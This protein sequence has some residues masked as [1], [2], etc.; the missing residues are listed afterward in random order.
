MA[1]ENNEDDSWLYGSSNEN[2]DNQDEQQQS[3]NDEN[4]ITNEESDQKDAE[5]SGNDKYDPDDQQVSRNE[6]PNLSNLAGHFSTNWF[7]VL[8][9]IESRQCR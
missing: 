2:Q 5:P 1:D 9:G 7:N 8:V 3:Q 4:I 6:F